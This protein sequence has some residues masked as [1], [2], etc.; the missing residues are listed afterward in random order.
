MEL[1]KRRQSR[2]EQ[3]MVARRAHADAVAKI[4]MMPAGPGRDAALAAL[5]T[6]NKP[7]MPRLGGQWENR[8][9]TRR[10]Q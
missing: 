8:L 9:T 2:V 1:R 3:S 5:D 7:R 4:Y 10:R 6:D